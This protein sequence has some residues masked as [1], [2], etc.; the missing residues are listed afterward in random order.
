V[1]AAGEGAVGP[2]GRQQP[3][4]DPALVAV[5]DSGDGAGQPDAELLG[6]LADAGVAAAPGLGH[7]QGPVAQVDAARVVE[8]VG[9]HGDAAVA[10]ASGR[11]GGPVRLPDNARLATIGANRRQARP[12]PGSAQSPEVDRG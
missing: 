12:L 8:V 2:G 9:D 5:P 10:G 1:R 6:R 4:D 7:L 3:G 11:S